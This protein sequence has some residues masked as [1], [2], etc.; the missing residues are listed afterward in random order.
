MCRCGCRGAHTLQPLWADIAW[1]FRVSGLVRRFPRQDSR[2]TSWPAD[3][4][5]AELAG[6]FFFCFFIFSFYFF[7]F[8]IF[9]FSFFF[10][11]SLSGQE[12]CGGKAGVL[13]EISCDLDEYPK[14]GGFP[15]YGMVHGCMKCDVHKD[16]LGNVGLRAQRRSHEDFVQ[17]ALA[18]D[19]DSDSEF[20]ILTL[21]LISRF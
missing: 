9:V 14:S 12:L 17:T 16:D 20:K 2:Q 1:M 8:F 5:R 13:I 3:S 7:V 21:I 18:S 19:S 10:S 11:F 4:V 15:H 6:L